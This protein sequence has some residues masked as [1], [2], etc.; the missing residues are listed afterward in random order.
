M[1]TT[2][3]HMEQGH[4][5]KLL[6]AAS[7]DAALLYLYLQSG[8]DPSSAAEALRLT[9]SR[10]QCA[11][12]TLRQLGLWQEDKPR[13]HLV[14]ERPQYSETDVMGAVNSD[15]EFR[16]LYSEI[17]QQL[18]R[19]LTT[20][21]L[22]ILL[23][24]VRYLG[25]P[26]DV[27]CVLVSYCKDRARQKGNLRNP[28]LR[29]I[30][31]EAYAWAERGIDTMEEAAAFIQSQNVRRS[32]LRQLMD[33]LQIRGR[34]LTAAEERYANAWLEMGFQKDVIVLAYERTCLNTGNL[35][36]AYMNKIL[37]RWHESGL[38]T[39][40]QVKNGDKKP[41]PKGASGQLGQAELDAIQKVLQ[42]V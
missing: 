4:V 14:G 30:E 29:V 10:V 34:D 39:V 16:S 35:S 36:W 23:G 37:T 22:K 19:T 28:S 17:Q 15:M 24:F 2:E 18:G 5:H 21:E 32:R 27:I 7:G 12:A 3:L 26:A 40:E 33:I 6:S 11:T 42:E 31:K 20:E 41:V 13:Q 8:N 38:H 9:Q 25:L 1:N